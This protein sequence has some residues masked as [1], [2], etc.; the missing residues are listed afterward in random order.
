MIEVLLF[1]IIAIAP[2]FFVFKSEGEAKKKEAE[3]AARKSA[4]TAKEIRCKSMAA[5]LLRH[6]KELKTDRNREA[7]LALSESI[8]RLRRGTPVKTHVITYIL[9]QLD[10]TED[11]IE[12]IKGV[13]A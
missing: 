1:I 8:Q 6:W 13:G 2:I 3:E 5:I 9:S 12:E 10:G 4:I 11:I 7:V